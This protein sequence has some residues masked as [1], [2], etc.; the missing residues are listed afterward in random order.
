MPNTGHILQVVHA[1]NAG[2]AGD[3]LRRRCGVLAHLSF[4]S[5]VAALMAQDKN[6]WC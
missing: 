1:A 3:W 2:P 6:G 5:L 4:S